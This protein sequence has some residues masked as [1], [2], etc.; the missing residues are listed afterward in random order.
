MV[1]W[2]W[3]APSFVIRRIQLQTG[4]RATLARVSLTHRLELEAYDV[5]IAG[6]PPFESRTLARADRV[7]VRLR[8][9]GG[10]LTPS[11][12]VID[13]LD[14]EYLGTDAGDNLRILSTLGKKADRS[15]TRSDE[16]WVPKIIVRSAR[17]RG[18]IEVPHMPRIAFRVPQAEIERTS[19]GRATACLHHV[20]VDTDGWGSLRAVILTVQLDRGGLVLAT[21]DKV[22]IEMPGGGPLLE[23]LV[24][25]A[26]HSAS[27]SEF[28]LR[29][30]VDGAARTLATG[31]WKQQSADLAVDIDDISLRPLGAMVS[32]RALGFENARASLHVSVAIER[33]AWRADYSFAG[34]IRGFD[35]LHPA[36]DRIPWRNQDVSLRLNGRVDMPTKRVD[37]ASG[38]LKT[39]GAT[40]AL[41]GWIDVLGPPRGSF[42]LAT[43]R[44]APLS[45]VSLFLAEPTPV[46]EVLSGL[47]LEG[48][49][50]LNLSIAFD[51]S[52]WEDLKLDLRLDPV[53]TVKR[54]ASVLANLLPALVNSSVSPPVSTKLPVG[55]SFADFV[56]LS[57]MPRHLPSAF[58]TSEDSKFFHHN[59]FDL[60]MIGHALAQDLESHAFGRG[61]STITQ[62]LAK[63][64]FLSNQ[65]TVARKLEEA[66]LTWRLHKLLSKDRVLELYLNVIELGPGIRGVGQAARVYFGKDVPALTPLEAAHLAALA[67][68]PHVLARRFREGQVDDGWRQRLYDLLGMMKRHGRLSPAELSAART[69]KLHLR[70][71]TQDGALRVTQ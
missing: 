11:E 6:A 59:G 12:I 34:R 62:Q 9:P 61:A 35:I 41:K 47:D 1:L 28:E 51:A 45:C 50:G 29:N 14:V 23:D 53:C 26:S 22:A 36:L 2:R 71:L 49:L 68:N 31:H 4:H 16:R 27:N 66:V 69:S 25:H 24:L 63:N 54:E 56:P 39:L 60:D 19:D 33:P 58:L 30:G 43:P 48:K 17:L 42:S 46:Q 32:R 40:L 44:R 38:E 67:P 18:T 37:V 57:L 70:D 65:R 10:I 20:V 52:A 55:R 13:G 15:I 21:G 8:G 5:R 7:T 3:K 64:L